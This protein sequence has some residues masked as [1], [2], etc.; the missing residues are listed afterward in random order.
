MT[1][2]IIL[3]VLSGK[4]KSFPLSGAAVGLAVTLGCSAVFTLKLWVNRSFCK[5]KK[6]NKFSEDMDTSSVY[7]QD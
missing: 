3:S 4:K 1:I 6:V 7:S 2:D 5:K